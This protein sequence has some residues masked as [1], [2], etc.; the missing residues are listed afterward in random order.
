PHTVTFR[1]VAP[2]YVRD[3]TWW[4]RVV[5]PDNLKNT[6]SVTIPAGGWE[7][8]CP[9]AAALR[10]TEKD[11][12]VACSMSM[13]ALTDAQLSWR[14]RERTTRLEQPVFYCDL[15]TYV[16]LTPGLVNMTH[17]ARY[18][19]AQGEIQTL[20]FRIPE[21]MSVTAVTG[22][23]LGTW[24]YEPDTRV[25]EALMEKPASGDF[26]LVIV[27]QIPREGLPYTASI[28]ALTVEGAAR[29]R[30]AMALAAAGAVQVRVDEVKGMNPMNTGDF[31]GDAV[32]CALVGARYPE[33]PELKRAYRYQE[34]PATVTVNADRVTPELRVTEQASLDISDERL[35][36]T[37]RLEM[38]ITRA[39]VFDLRLDLPPDFDI[40]AL[41]GEEISHW[42]EVREGGRGV[43]VHFKKQALGKRVLNLV[44]GRMERGIEAQILVPRIGVRDAVKH[45][46]TLAVSGE[47]G[48]RF[49]TAA[50][51]GVTEVHP[52]ELGIEQAG[53]L[54]FR[55]LRPDWSVSLKTEALA[56]VVR[57]DTLQR[58]DVSEGMIRGH[59]RLQYKIDQAGVKTFRLKAPAPGVALAVSGR[60]IAKVN[61]VD[62]AAGIWEVE[63]Q[64]KVESSDAMEV[65]SQQPCEPAA[66]TIKI[67]PVRTVGA[68]SQKGYV[69][70]F[71]SGRLQ[72]RAEKAPET[73]HAEDARNI[74]AAFGAGD[75]SDAIFCFRT[76]QP[77]FELDLS[78]VRHAVAE[79]LPAR[80]ESVA[81]TS[82][83]ADDG[84]M[85][86][87]VVMKLNVGSLRFLDVTLPK[88]AQVWSV[89]VN[90]AGSVPLTDRNKVMIPLGSARVTGEAT[91]ELTYVGT[92]DVAGRF[93]RERIEGPRF[94]IP[95]ADVQWDLYVPP[96]YRYHGF[97]GTLTYRKED[98]A[99]GVAVFEASQYELDNRSAVQASNQKAEAVLRAGESLWKQGK[100]AEA[101]QAFQQAVILSQGQQDL[102]EDARI[103]Y[104][105]VTRQQA[106][107]GFYN[108]RNALKKAQN[109]IELDVPNKPAAQNAAEQQVGQGQWTAD[110]GR[111]IE[112]SLGVEEAGNLNKVADK[113]LEQQ[114]AAQMRATPIR[115]TV[116]QQGL[117]LP[118]RRDLQIQASAEMG[119]QFKAGSGRVLGAF[120]SVGSALLLAALFWGALRMLTIRRS[121]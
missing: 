75:L 100:Q 67:L 41:T 104:Q 34:L 22:A 21:G 94:N 68:D 101:K 24:R 29:Q 93:G 97:G 92:A 88:G 113:M 77:D 16:A 58:V 105:N 36:L 71:T 62:K 73:L 112:Q 2:V 108:R 69:V 76:A 37:S 33:P 17:L 43:I 19:V 30:G 10:Q 85:V 87:R 31:P 38:S 72:V 63:L 3:G 96:N 1:G 6:V 52:K 28:G 14:P 103:Q 39:G 118:F 42:D 23:G 114:S 66:Q 56:P 46:G 115:V 120:A 83:V 32:K 50:K 82:V 80:V 79:V 26:T 102:N 110:Y 64:G 40:E 20:R 98:G 78:V 49:L 116:P 9:Q 117:H 55:L 45:V 53:Y 44:L 107:V 106:V 57:A 91:I 12:T 5:L 18:Q 15:Q 99:G 47:R 111:Q 48:V 8:A 27:T 59:C 11:K 61:E 70:V 86:T 60:N 90:D 121:I 35:V 95:L 81:M 4:M 119:V 84:Q 25:L 54:A 109:V 7:V 89:F 65:D 13:V 74:P 51:D